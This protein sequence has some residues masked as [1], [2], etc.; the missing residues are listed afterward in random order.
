M[1]KKLIVCISVVIS[2]I[3][4]CAS[5]VWAEA[6][7]ADEEEPVMCESQELKLE[8]DGDPIYG[9]LYLPL[10]EKEKYPVV[11]ISHGFGGTADQ[12]APVAEYFAEH[13]FA[14]YV[15]D[16]IGGS[17]KSRSGAADGD[18]TKMSV[19]TEATDLSAVIDQIRDLEFIDPDNL[20]LIGQSQGGY[21]SSY[22]AAQRPED[23]KAMV[24][25]YPAYALQDDCWERHGSIENVPETEHFMGQ[26][27]GA[28]YSLDAM[29]MDIY[30][31]I[32]AYTGDVLLIH[33]DNDKLVD[34]SYSEKAADVYENEEFLV[35]E[36]AGHG[37]SGETAV[38]ANEDM[39]GFIEAHVG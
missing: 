32:G 29:S 23:I 35:Y 9:V 13:G 11:I 31:I 15:Y 37:F 7:P 19:L 38:R 8:N 21:V 25:E 33:G 26:E 6:A 34:I 4:L 36:G 20:F 5:A 18:M 28:I 30:D 39:L 17:V 27:L 2:M 3:I 24:L 16:F 22:V 1:K 14:A 10:E 12:T